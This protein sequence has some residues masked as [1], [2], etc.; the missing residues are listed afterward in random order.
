MGLGQLCATT[1]CSRRMA[2]HVSLDTFYNKLLETSTYNLSVTIDSATTFHNL[3]RLYSKHFRRKHIDRPDRTGRSISFDPSGN[4][5]YYN[6]ALL[7]LQNHAQ[8]PL[9]RV[10]AGFL[11]MVLVAIEVGIILIELCTA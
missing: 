11:K 2:D 4:Y 9:P 10:P 7:L 5:Y 8:S 6:K 1:L 3:H